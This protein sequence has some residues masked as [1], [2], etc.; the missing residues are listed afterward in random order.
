MVIFIA[1]KFFERGNQR[2]A[3]V[4]C[5]SAV[6]ICWASTYQVPIISGIP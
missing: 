1:L 5:R 6:L 2:E 3:G 4:A